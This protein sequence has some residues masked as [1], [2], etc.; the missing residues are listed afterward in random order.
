MLLVAGYAGVGKTTL[1]QELYKPLV[2]SRGYYI[3]GKFDQLERNMPYRALIQ[4][5]RQL[6]QRLLTE[7]EA[8]LEA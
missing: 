8:R 4:A 5:F 6:I 2:R 3:S 7:G 1:I